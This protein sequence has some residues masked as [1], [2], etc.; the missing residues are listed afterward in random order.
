M[1][2]PALVDSFSSKAP[3]GGSRRGWKRDEGWEYS[4]FLVSRRRVGRPR[5]QWGDQTAALTWH[6]LALSEDIYEHATDSD[7]LYWEAALGNF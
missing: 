3:N 1:P 5:L 7:R 4:V 2:T 6:S